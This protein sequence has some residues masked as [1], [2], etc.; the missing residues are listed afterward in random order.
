MKTALSLKTRRLQ[1]LVFVVAS[2]S[3]KN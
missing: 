1:P 3:N 2:L